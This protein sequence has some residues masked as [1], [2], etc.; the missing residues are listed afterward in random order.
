MSQSLRYNL[1][2]SV[3]LLSLAEHKP[4]TTFTLGFYVG[5]RRTGTALFRHYE[6][7]TST[8]I[9]M[10]VGPPTTLNMPHLSRCYSDLSR[11]LKQVFLLP[12]TF[13][14]LC[15]TT[16]IYNMLYQS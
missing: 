10:V 6:I 16:H 12:H 9:S 7:I 15:P 8:E 5:T 3:P 1:R 4:G 14:S 13:K 2:H 11:V